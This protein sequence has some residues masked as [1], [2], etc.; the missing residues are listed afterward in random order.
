MLLQGLPI[1]GNYN[2]VNMIPPSTAATG[3]SNLASDVVSLKKYFAIDTVIS[4]ST[5][6]AASVLTV[7]KSSDL[8]A[9]ST[10][11]VPFK[12]HYS[13]QASVDT[14]STEQSA[15]STGISLG[16]VDNGLVAFRITQEDLISSTAGLSG[17]TNLTHPNVYFTLT[18]STGQTVTALGLMS[19]YRYLRQPMPTAIS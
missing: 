1:I 5:H 19:G 9:N 6:A 18:G 13:T 16:T 12:Y 2:V 15:T 14:L 11:A 8:T 4:F 3:S 10:Q 7:Y 17:T